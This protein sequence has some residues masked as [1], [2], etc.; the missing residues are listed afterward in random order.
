[1]RNLSRTK[2]FKKDLKRE[3]KG[4]YKTTLES[5]LQAIIE[6]L[7]NDKELPETYCDHPMV[8]EWKG[9]RDAHIKP[10]LIL[11][12]AK[13]SNDELQLVRIGSHS[14]LGI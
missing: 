3:S 4:Q 2:Q 13:V 12:Y 14:E 7:L 8:G 1:M 5:E 11:I 6:L 10:D 9:Y